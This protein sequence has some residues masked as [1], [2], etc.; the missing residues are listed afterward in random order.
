MIP[1]ALPG[2]HVHETGG[3]AQ[4]SKS[5]MKL[6]VPTGFE[7]VTFGLGNRCSILLSYGTGGSSP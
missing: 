3:R 1:L 2:N 4:S 6:A 7:P 5:L